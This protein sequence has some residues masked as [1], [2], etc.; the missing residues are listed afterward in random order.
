VTPPEPP[1]PSKPALPDG[2]IAFCTAAFR[3]FS[4]WGSGY[5]AD[6]HIANIGAGPIE[7]WTISWT[8]NGNQKVRDMWNA[9]FGQTGASVLVRDADWNAKLPE[10]TTAYFGFIADYSGENSAPADVM[11]N[12]FPCLMQP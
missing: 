6:L 9:R 12:G 2:Q 10:N 8:F 11:L 5:N 1:A 4:D 3:I 7:G